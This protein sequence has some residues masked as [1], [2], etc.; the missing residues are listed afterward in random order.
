M[1]PRH[2]RSEAAHV[3]EHF[4]G[5]LTFKRQIFDKETVDRR[6]R[7]GARAG[8]KL[9]ISE[10][11]SHRSSCGSLIHYV[12]RGFVSFRSGLGRRVVEQLRRIWFNVKLPILICGEREK[13][14][15]NRK[16]LLCI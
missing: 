10:Y 13:K 3:N 14:G 2:R 8:P 15:G 4:L 6:P 5:I 16:T 12:R 11:R 9:R 7:V 1:T